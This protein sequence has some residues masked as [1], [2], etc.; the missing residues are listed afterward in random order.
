[1]SQLDDFVGVVLADRALLDDFAAITDGAA[2]AAACVE[3]GARLGFTFTLAEVDDAM[4]TRH[5]AWL[6]RR[7]EGAK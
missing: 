7:L 4:R 2:F 1:M 5:L 6:Q 3:T